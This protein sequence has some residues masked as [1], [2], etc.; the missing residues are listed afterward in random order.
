MTVRGGG[1]PR[2]P[3][4]LTPNGRMGPPLRSFAAD[5]HDCIMVRVLGPTGYKVVA[6]LNRAPKAGSPLIVIATALSVPSC[7]KPSR[8]GLA[9]AKH[10]ARLVRRPILTASA[11]IDL[12]DAP[13]GM[14][15]RTLRSNQETDEGKRCAA[16]ANSLTKKAPYKGL[17]ADSEEKHEPV[18]DIDTGMV[19]SLKVLDPKW[20]IRE[21]D[22]PDAKRAGS[23]PSLPFDE[24]SCRTA[25][26]G[27]R[28]TV[29]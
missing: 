29:W 23:D 19:A 2:R 12:S 27:S 4:A 13:V 6:R 1:I 20:P 5:A 7:S 18:S 15:K 21:A 3:L 9:R 25:Q 28:A 10:A 14:K 16:L 8:Y 17:G 26:Q 22:N 24:H 11:R